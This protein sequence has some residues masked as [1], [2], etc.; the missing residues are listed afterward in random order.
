KMKKLF[1]LLCLPFL[2]VNCGSDTIPLAEMPY[3]LQFTIPAGLSPFENWYFLFEDIPN[4]KNTV[5]NSASLSDEEIIEIRGKSANLTALFT[6]I[7]F[8]FIHDI[9]IRIFKEDPD[10]YRELFYRTEIPFNI[11]GDLG[12]IGG[13]TDVQQY[14]QDDTYNIL[15]KIIPRAS[16]PEVIDCRLD[17]VIFAR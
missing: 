6:N 7:E 1:Y 17:Y 4:N 10:D 11:S 14:L 8:D 9:S 15:I 2:L 5:F 12:L 13:E 16:T 3:Q